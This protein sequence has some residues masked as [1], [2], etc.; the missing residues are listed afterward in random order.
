MNGLETNFEEISSRL[1]ELLYSS[2]QNGIGDSIL[3]SGGLDTS[4]IAAMTPTYDKK[5]QAFTLI[6][7]DS[8]A[9]DLVYSKI[10]AEKFGFEHEIIMVDFDEIEMILPEAIKVLRSFD[11]MEVRNSVAIFL[12]MKMAES[13]G[14]TRVLTGDGADELF[15]GYDFVISHQKT[16]SQTILSH[17]W[18]VMHFSSIPLARSLGIEAI[19]PYLDE[20]VRDFAMQ[21][22]PFEYLVGESGGQTFG[23]YIL[24]KA[25]ENM[26]PEEIVWR[27]K[28]PIEHGSGTTILPM[29]YSKRMSNDEF[30]EKKRRIFESDGVRIR[31]KEQL[32][33]YEFYR[34][35]FGPPGANSSGRICP[36]CNSKIL[37]L[38]TFCVTCGEYPI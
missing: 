15:A 7:N 19:L 1:R 12:C 18:E 23:K 38:T 11:P 20:K 27:K 3:L 37:K 33:Y 13:R 8:P 2:I 22:I 10:V 9:T 24:R 21:K 32:H 28:T 36:A 31:D 26:L 29:L 30:S 35:E 34:N 5:I 25:F 4:I 14:F 17:L 6:M 16:E